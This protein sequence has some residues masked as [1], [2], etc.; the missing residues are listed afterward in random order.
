MTQ[1]TPIPQPMHRPLDE[2]ILVVRRETLFSGGVAWQ[3][4]RTVDPEQYEAV[5][6]THQ[7]F[8]PR[9]RMETDPR[10]KQI[11][12]YL[13]FTYEGTYFV[14]E[15]LAKATET[16]L[17]S[18]LSLGIGGHINETDI[19]GGTIVSW[20]EREFAEEV[21]YTGSLRIEP[22]GVLNDDSSDVGKVH[23]GFVYMVH[24]DSSH[25]VAR[26]EFKSGTLMTLEECCAQYDRMEPWSQLIL[27]H[28][29]VQAGLPARRL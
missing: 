14:M 18:K 24:G 16:R 7:E 6:R 9:S 21:A 23:I 26:E 22:F 11:I 15:R 1:Q 29:M 19:A 25:I 2:Q 17:S 8:L 5:V 4:L 10:Y 3:G 27:D 13:V 20:A 12:P 28:L